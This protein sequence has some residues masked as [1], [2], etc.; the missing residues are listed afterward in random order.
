MT[1]H[2]TGLTAS[3]LGPTLLA[4]AVVLHLAL[5]LGFH[6]S[7]DEAHYALYASH[8]D[9]SYFDHPPLVGWVQWP[10]LML[11]GRDF[12][13]RVVPMA[14]WLLAAVGVMRLTRELY[15]LLG[16]AQAALLLLV[17]SPMPHLLGLAL[18]PDSLLLPIT[19]GVMLLCWRLC[20]V[21]WLRRTS[22]WLALGV[23]LGLAGLSKYT[24]VML[25]L[26]AALV[27]LR[28]HG[29]RLLALPG[30]WMA[31]VLALI[32]ITPVLGWNATH[33]WISFTYQLGH[34]AGAQEW[35]LGRVGVFLLVQF[36]VFGCLL[37]VGLIA[38]VRSRQVGTHVARGPESTTSQMPISP[39]SPISPLFFCVCF[40]L[41]SLLLFAFLSG[42]GSAL[43]HWT[44]PG[45]LAL[46]PP[47]AA[48]CVVLWTRHRV[49]LMVMGAVQ[50]LTFAVLAGLMLTGGVASEKDA[51]AQSQ[52]GQ[53]LDTAPVNPFADL[54][55]WDA[56]AVRGRALAQ[57]Q[58]VK[59]LA[60][61]NWTLANRIA[62]YARPLPVK[63]VQRHFD[64]FD[65]WFGTLVPGES[66]VLI[67]WSLMSFAPPV[68][69]QQFERCDVLE[70]LPARR[71]GRQIAH[72]S[73]MLC[74]N[75]QGPLEPPLG[76]PG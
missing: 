69:P 8:L 70:Q 50:A 35:R 24:A 57:M 37:L 53:M 3:R 58:G 48:G 76:R 19:C 15:P 29:K 36:I 12:L 61:M 16:S 68:G 7:P 9:W 60:V 22:L 34:V 42:R 74:R 51:Q 62:W 75:W 11:G 4:G 67:D 18:V 23:C 66:V 63:V 20:D 59:T 25:A 17:L 55:G 64:Q 56:A 30:P 5:A 40:G 72:F 44:A 6:L 14:C 33:N 49:P 26:G 43:P 27:L 10:A 2:L 47:A 39:I 45:W 73:Y 1:P 28:V 31:V 41:P 52:P 54:H 21:T 65:L 32:L 13:M 46:M 38:V 71:M